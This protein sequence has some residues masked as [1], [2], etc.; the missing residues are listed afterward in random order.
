MASTQLATREQRLAALAIQDVRSL[1]P[2]LAK[3]TETEIKGFILYCKAVNADPWAKEIYL[4]KYDE[5]APAAIALA[6]NWYL[7]RASHNPAYESY[8]SGVTV[9]RQGTFI[10]LVGSVVYPGDKLFGGWCK[11]Y[12]KGADHPFERRVAMAEYD[13]RQ[14]GWTKM[15]ATM[16][17]KVAIM[18]GIRRAFPDEFS[19]EPEVGLPVVIEGEIEAESVTVAQQSQVMNISMECPVHPGETWRLVRG[20]YMHAVDGGKGPRGGTVWCYQ[21]Q[22]ESQIPESA[23]SETHEDA[24]GWASRT[25]EVLPQGQALQK[26]DFKGKVETSGPSSGQGEMEFDVPSITIADRRLKF[27]EWAMEKYMVN[28]NELLDV[29]GIDSLVVLK[30]EVDLKKAVQVLRTKYGK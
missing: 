26:A 1:I 29:L 5:K 3:C 28:M 9:E 19:E 2:G 21:D 22:V 13:K 12:K 17:E 16:I 27:S 20:R 8:E 4:I 6:L 25:P 15:P 7:K 30:D 24:L 18:Q 14:A 10:D 23:Q 11:V